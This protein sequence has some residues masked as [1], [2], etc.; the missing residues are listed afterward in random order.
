MRLGVSRPTACLLASPTKISGSIEAAPLHVNNEAASVVD[1][2]HGSP[3]GSLDSTLAEL[4][5]TIPIHSGAQKPESSMKPVNK[6]IPAGDEKLARQQAEWNMMDADLRRSIE[7][8]FGSQDNS[9]DDEPTNAEIREG[10]DGIVRK[11]NGLLEQVSQST[12]KG[13]DGM[14]EVPTIRT[15]SVI[16]LYSNSTCRHMESGKE[17]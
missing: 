1:S 7:D 13:L 16:I 12:L 14:D 4:A 3:A 2:P 15:L 11:A 17:N 10:T 9:N 6:A 5:A 8:L